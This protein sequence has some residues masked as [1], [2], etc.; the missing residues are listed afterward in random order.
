MNISVLLH[1]QGFTTIDLRRPE[2]V[3]LRARL[4]DGPL[5]IIGEWIPRSRLLAVAFPGKFLICSPF[6]RSP[7]LEAYPLEPETVHRLNTSAD[8]CLVQQDSVVT[9][10]GA[11]GKQFHVPSDLLYPG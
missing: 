10:F 2:E 1:P 11:I 8:A 7:V 5:E 4:S 9:L 6:V 3:L